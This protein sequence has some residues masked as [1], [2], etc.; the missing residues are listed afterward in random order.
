MYRLFLLINW[1]LRNIFCFWIISRL[2]S[3]AAF[4]STPAVSSEAMPQRKAPS[5]WLLRY[6][7]AHLLEYNYWIINTPCWCCLFDLGTEYVIRFIVC[8]MTATLEVR[9][10]I[11]RQICYKSHKEKVTAQFIFNLIILYT[12][13]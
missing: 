11:W 3:T 7:S 12:L 4:L 9:T 13:Q 10:G 2:V 8:L 6:T 5:L 1:I